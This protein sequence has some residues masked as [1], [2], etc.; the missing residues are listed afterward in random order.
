MRDNIHAPSSLLLFN[1]LFLLTL[2]TF[3]IVMSPH[4]KTGIEGDLNSVARYFCRNNDDTFATDIT[5]FDPHNN[6]Y[7][8]GS[9][10]V[11]PRIIT[12]ESELFIHTLVRSDE[13]LYR[14]QRNSNASEFDEASLSVHG[15]LR[16][17]NYDAHL[18]YRLHMHFC[19][20]HQICQKCNSTRTATET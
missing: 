8:P 11:N 19:H 10:G 13:G 3:G 6:T 18:L 16:E 2:A 1:T 5:W 17:H 15:M 14:C 4:T 12:E 20:S 7:T 9:S